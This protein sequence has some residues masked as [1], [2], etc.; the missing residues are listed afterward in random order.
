MKGSPIRYVKGVET[1]LLILH[2]EEDERVPVSQAISFMRGLRRESTYPERAQL[3]IYPR[4]KHRSVHSISYKILK[5][6]TR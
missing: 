6:M 3:V 2:G 1:A 5:L 4:E